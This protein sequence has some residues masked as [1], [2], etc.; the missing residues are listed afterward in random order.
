[1][2]SRGG[3]EFYRRGVLATVAHVLK[4]ERISAFYVGLIPALISVIP[5]NAVFYTVYDS[6]KANHLRQL[7]G[8]KKKKSGENDQDRDRK[9]SS[10]DHS[11][12]RAKN[13][14]KIRNDEAGSALEEAEEMD[15]RFNLLYGGLAGIAA[16]TSVYPLEVIR[17]RLQIIAL[18]AR[19]KGVLD[20]IYLKEMMAAMSMQT[21][22]GGLQLRYS[23]GSLRGMNTLLRCIINR[24]GMRGFYWGVLPTACQ[25]L[26]S[27][28][29]S[30]YIFEECKKR[31]KVDK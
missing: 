15:P 7:S 8:K 27:A 21:S 17:R 25:V 10:S 12:H 13:S 1:M 11:H 26:P 19:N 3:E 28:A 29:I 30:Y 5:S 14:A 31:L 23:L 22:K 2:L 4:R 6:L 24:E 18:A 16:E 9:S 20:S